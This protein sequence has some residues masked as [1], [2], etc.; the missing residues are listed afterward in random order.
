[1]YSW[2][3]QLCADLLLAAYVLLS[4]GPRACAQSGEVSWATPANIPQSGAA[5][6]PMLVTR[7]DGTLLVLRWDSFEGLMV[8]NGTPPGP[9]AETRTCSRPRLVSI[10]LPEIVF[11]RRQ[12]ET[13]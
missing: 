11:C 10:V 4:S 12:E 2:S 5:S 8:A 7:S 9:V 1:M 13:H 3:G 6:S